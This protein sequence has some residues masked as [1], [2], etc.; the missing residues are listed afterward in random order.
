MTNLLKPIS[1]HVLSIAFL[2]AMV[3]AISPHQALA[4][5]IIKGHVIY[6]KNCII[7]HGNNGLSTMAGAA[8]FNRGEG[9]LKPDH[10][11]MERVKKGNNACP[12]YFGIL[13]EQQI[14]DVIAYIRTLQR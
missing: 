1:T 13:K 2:L 3:F 7:C 14:F 9:L 5:N 4:S 8:N 11:L 10:V 12:S 6:Q